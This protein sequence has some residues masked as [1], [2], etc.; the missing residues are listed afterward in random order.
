MKRN[1]EVKMP[2]PVNRSFEGNFPRF[3]QNPNH[4]FLK[5]TKSGNHLISSQ[6]NKVNQE[7]LDNVA[8]RLYQDSSRRVQNKQNQTIQAK[9]EEVENIEKLQKIGSK[10]QQRKQKKQGVCYSQVDIQKPIHERY[11][12]M[13]QEKQNKI[14]KLRYLDQLRKFEK[15]PDAFKPSFRPNT[16]LSQNGV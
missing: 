2:L 6:Q 11:E 7:I 16:T 1:T 13:L 5:K 14:E 4:N 3:K 12:Q 15:D 10:L 9:R 8:N